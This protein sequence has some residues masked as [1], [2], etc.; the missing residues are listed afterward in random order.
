MRNFDQLAR[1]QD[2]SV[3]KLWESGIVS[4]DPNKVAE[5]IA[6]G[7][8]VN[9]PY[10]TNTEMR[11]INNLMTMHDYLYGPNS[12][13][14]PEKKENLTKIVRMIMN[15]GPELMEKDVYGLCDLDRVMIRSSDHDLA[16][17]VV[18]TSLL[19]SAQKGQ[20]TYQIS[21]NDIFTQPINKKTAQEERQSW[22]DTIIAV[23]DSVRKKLANPTNI[24]EQDLVA[25]H[26][27]K[28]SLWMKPIDMPPIKNLPNPPKAAMDAYE[29]LESA[30]REM[31]DT[32]RSFLRSGDP[33]TASVARSIGEEAHKHRAEMARIRN[34]F[35]WRQP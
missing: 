10:T 33:Y 35:V 14:P 27:D 29:R 6:R 24:L 30:A 11:A 20:D 21:L 25:N 2:Y 15:E 4:K 26:S 17:D 5:A 31:G 28:V 9:A 34:N 8:N 7:A 22:Y 32:A 12:K 13:Y 3:T 18:I 23:H 19:Q 1:G 16:A